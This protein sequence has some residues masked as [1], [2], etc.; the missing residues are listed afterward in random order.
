MLK[1]LKSYLFTFVY[2][3]GSISRRS[4]DKVELGQFHIGGYVD[5]PP[6]GPTVEH[7]IFGITDCKTENGAMIDNR[8]VKPFW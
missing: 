6:L 5:S 8:L 4:S 3:R 2:N 7:I 1:H